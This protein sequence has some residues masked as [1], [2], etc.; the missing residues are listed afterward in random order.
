[1]TTATSPTRP[2]SPTDPSTPRS[3]PFAGT[4]M[5]LRLNLR[6]DRIQLPAWFFGFLILVWASVYA[7]EEAYPTPEALQ[8]RAELLNNPA[9]IMM[10]GPLFAAENYTLGA[11]IANELSV[12]VFL[13]AAIMSVLLMVRH[14]RAQEESGQL[15]MLRALPISRFAPAIAAG[16]TVAIANVLV[17]SAVTLALIGS[18]GAALDSLAFGLATGLT[19]MVFGALTAVIAQTTEYA[20]IVRGLS[21]GI[22]ALAYVVRGMGDVI[23]TQGSWL[24]WFSPFAW[25]Q[26]TKLYVDLRFWPLLVSVAAIIGFFLVAAALNHRRDLGAGLWQAADGRAEAHRWLLSP[27]GL[28]WR[29]NRGSFLGW[30]VGLFLLTA[31]MGSLANELE[32][33]LTTTPDLQA[34]VELNLDD[35]TR[36]FA[37]LLVSFSMLA[38]ASLMAGGVLSIRGEESAGRLEKMLLTGS[39]TGFVAGW[40]TVTTVLSVLV[41][42]LIGLGVGT[43]VAV[44]NQDAS[45]LEELVVASLAYLPAVLFFGGL[46]LALYGWVPRLASLVWL[47]V[48]WAAIDVFLGELF[49][50]PDWVRGLSPLWHVPLVPG[51]EVTATPL[52]ILTGLAIVLGAVGLIGLTRRDIQDR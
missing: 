39:R 33:M 11:A 9:A 17:A 25:A 46:A 21:L 41:T 10:T 23:N 12:Y 35:L 7:I 19:G 13:P 8:S 5:L 30:G 52:L 22:I 48:V 18:G 34:W 40:L 20:G 42:I 31:A 50:L 28:S 27:A 3:S 36:S 6:I 16:I 43:G 26:Q 2:S 45:W 15:E 38:P 24:S 37:A 51:A 4:G 47:V 44:V 1:M 49:D 14:T 29:L 32:T